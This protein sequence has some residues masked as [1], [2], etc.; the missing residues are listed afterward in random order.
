[1][2]GT[3]SA[4]WSATFRKQG[5]RINRGRPSRSETPPE[6]R[7][8]IERHPVAPGAPGGDRRAGGSG[9][10]DENACYPKAHAAATLRWPDPGLRRPTADFEGPGNTTGGRLA[11]AARRS[12]CA[13]A[14]EIK[15]PPMVS[16]FEHRLFSEISKELGRRTAPQPA[17]IR[18]PEL[19]RLLLRSSR[20]KLTRHNPPPTM[21]IVEGSGAVPT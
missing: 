15:E 14:G 18:D 2:S 11:E 7:L 6:Q 21:N 16:A 12:G 8:V 4:V 3:N 20:L 19:Y 5:K 13:G 9:P 17:A 10:H 1:M